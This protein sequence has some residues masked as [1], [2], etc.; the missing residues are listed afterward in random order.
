MKAGT[1][2]F[3]TTPVPLKPVRYPVGY[4]P[5]F[6]YSVTPVLVTVGYGPG[7]GYSRLR[8][9]FGLQRYIIIPPPLHYVIPGPTLLS[10]L[11]SSLRMRD[12]VPSITPTAFIDE[13]DRTPKG[14][15]GFATTKPDGTSDMGRLTLIGYNESERH[16]G[17]AHNCR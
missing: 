17:L 8:A 16:H 14:E 5:G 6:G 10:L 13:S 11:M 2:G 4:G 12:R 7:F 3:H 9:R 15:I 1:Q